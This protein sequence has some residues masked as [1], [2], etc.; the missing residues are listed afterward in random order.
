[1]NDKFPMFTTHPR[2]RSRSLSSPMQ[3]E[4]LGR[5][6]VALA[7]AHALASFSRAGARL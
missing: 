7:A 3:L 6:D 1:M 5:V 2:S 4:Q